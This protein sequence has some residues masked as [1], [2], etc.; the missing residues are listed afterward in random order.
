MYTSYL[1]NDTNA[2]NS[3]QDFISKKLTE[4]LFTFIKKNIRLQSRE[5]KYTLKMENNEINIIENIN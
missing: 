5:Q 2:Y 1:Q 4:N 3:V